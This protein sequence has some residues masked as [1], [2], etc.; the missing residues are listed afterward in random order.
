MARVNPIKCT[1]PSWTVEAQLL[2]LAVEIENRLNLPL[3]FGGESEAV[4]NLAKS[5][6]ADGTQIVTRPIIK[7]FEKAWK[8]R[9]DSQ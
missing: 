5:I 9:P 2:G 6:I 3:S 1:F 7:V 4:G 8:K